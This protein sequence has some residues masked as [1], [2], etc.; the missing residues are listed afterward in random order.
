MVH[1]VTTRRERRNERTH[2]QEIDERSDDA[3]RLNE[4]QNEKHTKYSDI[5][6][7]KWPGRPLFKWGAVVP[8]VRERTHVRTESTL[9]GN[10]CSAR[11][12]MATRTRLDH[13]ATNEATT[14]GSDEE[15]LRKICAIVTTA[16]R[17]RDILD[18]LRYRRTLR[19]RA[20]STTT[21]RTRRNDLNNERRYDYPTNGTANDAMRRTERIT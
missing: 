9:D 5:S 19:S 1:E 15:I 8:L 18:K 21:Q 14:N 20:N 16:K 13:V 12:S 10:Y 3:P 11:I 7:N 17:C 4:R 6:R 2:E